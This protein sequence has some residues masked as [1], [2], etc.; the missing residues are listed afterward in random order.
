MPKYAAG[1]R[2]IA[3]KYFKLLSHSLLTLSSKS[4]SF[5]QEHLPAAAVNDAAHQQHIFDLDGSELHVLP[6]PQDIAGAL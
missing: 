2:K 6:H 4:A 3:R 5:Y 1:K